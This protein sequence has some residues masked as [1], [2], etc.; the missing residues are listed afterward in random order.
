MERS[1]QTFGKYEV[2]RPLA[3][4][5]MGEVLLA[6]QVGLPGFDRLIVLKKVLPHLAQD[7]D[8]IQR[9]LDET[10]VA[11]A[12]AHGNIVQVSEVGEFDGQYSMAM[13]FVDGLDL[14]ELLAALRAHD[15][16][17]PEHLAL[18]V[19]VEVAKALAYAH[20]RKGPDGTPLGIVHRDVSPANL[21][22]SNDGQVKLTDFG[23][24]KAAAR[25]TLSLPGT[26]HGKVYYMSPEQVTGLDVDAR[27]D[28]FSLGVVAYEILCG[29]RPFEGDSEVAVIDAVRRCVPR[30]LREIAPWVSPSLE[31]LV[32][33]AL[34]RDPDRRYPTMHE[35][36]QALTTYMLEAHTIVSARAM[37]DFVAQVQKDRPSSTP[38]SQ[39]P[40]RSLD[41]LAA[42]LLQGAGDASPNNRTRTVLGPSEPVTPV[43][44]RRGWIA[45]WLVAAASLASVVV[46]LIASGMQEEHGGLADGS[47][48]PILVATDV[49]VSPA[50][51]ADPDATTED[52]APEAAAAPAVRPAPPVEEVV[53]P[54]PPARTFAKLRSTP[55]GAEVW[56]GDRQLG[57]TPLDVPLPKTG[58][59]RVELRLDGYETKTL[60]LGPESAAVQNVT[61]ARLAVGHVHFRFFPADA[62]VLVDG[63]P[64]K[65]S[66]NLVTLELPDGPHVLR[67]MSQAGDQGKEVHFAVRALE[68]TEL[69][70]VELGPRPEG[71]HEPAREEGK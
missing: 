15:Q 48:A 13:A 5:G 69:G 58:S 43:P 62:Q 70:T 45:P 6:R 17:M 49:V 46:V 52:A 1:G 50:R 59:L 20:E 65:T 35:F 2:L 23:V 38:G 61:L 67:L 22:L 14:K 19:L 11:S 25:L 39:T 56:Q 64:Q 4:G 33:R 8:F 28:I 53:E 41:D 51:A 63:R 42:A 34:E 71:G 7:P 10:R 21:L 37:A 40:P 47:A 18:Y 29:Q 31:A 32:E 16:R 3:S 60:A 44:V 57:A 54:V 9:F 26:L 24:A 36:E 30:P 66:G 55:R 68:T 12:L 27:S